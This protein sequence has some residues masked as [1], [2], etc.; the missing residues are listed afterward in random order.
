[1]ALP[2]WQ[3]DKFQGSVSYRPKLVLWLPTSLSCE[4]AETNYF[5]HEAFRVMVIRR[6][7]VTD[8]P[9]FWRGWKYSF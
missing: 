3:D 5:Y 1:M 8:V 2:N 6:G 4:M 9:R 7:G